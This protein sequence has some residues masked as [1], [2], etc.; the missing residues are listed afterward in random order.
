M[1]IQVNEMSSWLGRWSLLQTFDN[2]TDCDVAEIRQILDEQT[3]P[4]GKKD[5]S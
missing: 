5:E 1:D 2:D 3:D 4:D